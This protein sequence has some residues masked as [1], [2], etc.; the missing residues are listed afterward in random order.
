MGRLRLAALPL[1]YWLSVSPV[2]ADI[3][4]S[5]YKL[6]TSIRSEKERQRMNVLLEAEKNIA[7]EQRRLEEAGESLRVIEKK[8]AWEL[9]PYPVRLTE[10]RCT[11]CHI[12]TDFTKQRHNQ[13]GW[14]LVILRMQYFNDAPLAE[15]ERGVIA[16]HLTET[17]P[18]TGEAALIEMLQQLALALSPVWLLLALK[19]T[20][21]R[22]GRSRR[23]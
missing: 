15:G 16:A 3:D 1:L 9:L 2:M 13:I 7:D 10:T 20:R 4:P 14:E 21:S 22:F 5:E 23:H 17:Y 8:E 19:T 6:K 11:A 12:E 18:A